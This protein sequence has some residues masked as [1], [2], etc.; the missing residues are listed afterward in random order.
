[1]ADQIIW[2]PQVRPQL[3]LMHCDTDEVFFGGARGPSPL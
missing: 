1:M 2:R 3:D